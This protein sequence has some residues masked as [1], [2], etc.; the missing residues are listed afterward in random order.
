MEL[1]FFGI[2]I[3]ALVSVWNTRDLIH[4]LRSARED[5]KRSDGTKTGAKND[6]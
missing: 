6:T 3:H 5:A 1:I 4:E 2:V